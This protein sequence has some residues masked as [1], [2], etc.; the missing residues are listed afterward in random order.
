MIEC[1]VTTIK[2]LKIGQNEQLELTKQTM[3]CAS[4]MDGA[5]CQGREGEDPHIYFFENFAFIHVDPP[6]IFILS[7]YG[8][9]TFSGFTLGISRMMK[10]T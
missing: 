2:T 9:N 8:P 10:V 1:R 6:R 3:Y 5:N 7:H 4:S